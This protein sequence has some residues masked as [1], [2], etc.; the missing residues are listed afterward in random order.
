MQIGGVPAGVGGAMGSNCSM[1]EDFLFGVMKHLGNG[2]NGWLH[3]IV[4]VL[5]ANKLFT[6]K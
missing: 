2:Q 6:L 1:D 3:N 5:I 4:N